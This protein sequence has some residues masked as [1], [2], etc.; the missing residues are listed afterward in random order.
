MTGPS[1]QIIT[2]VLPH[3]LIDDAIDKSQKLSGLATGYNE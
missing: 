2:A 3:P 1:F